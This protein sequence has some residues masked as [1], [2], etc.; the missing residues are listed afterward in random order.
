MRK[1]WSCRN[2]LY[3]ALLAVLLAA[4]GC[5]AVLENLPRLPSAA[6]PVTLS[7]PGV[8]LR[9]DRQDPY[10]VFE[11]PVERGAAYRSIEVE[12]DFLFGGYNSPLFHTVASLRGDGIVFALTLRGDRGRTLFDL[13]GNG[14]QA[15]K[16]PWRSGSRYH[17]RVQ[18]DVE[19]NRAVL[20]VS[21]GGRLVQRLQG[22]AGRRRLGAY[23]GK[24]L[25]LDFSQQK[26]YDD[27]FYPL[28]G[29][30]YSDLQVR[31]EP[32]GGFNLPYPR[33]VRGDPSL[34]LPKGG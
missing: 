28:W 29:S 33:A 2:L 9:A 19:E 15:G 1:P 3:A 17:V 10:R 31:L 23:G 34:P 4:G 7:R 26:A 5:A 30:T 12:F 6:Q 20:E 14:T 25:R 11:L 24:P 18:V 16:G 8:F 32:A 22:K 13:P 27:A 21:Q